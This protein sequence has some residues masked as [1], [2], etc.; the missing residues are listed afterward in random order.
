MFRP[1][2]VAA[3]AF[4]LSTGC[5]PRLVIS[6]MQPGNIN[7]GS[8]ERVKIIDGQGRRSA[9]EFLNH[10]A[11]SQLRSGG[12]FSVL[13]I[14][15][16][17]AHLQISGRTASLEGHELSSGE[18]VIRFDV[19]EWT[20]DTE[21]RKEVEED[22]EGNEQVKEVR[23]GIGTVVM[24]VTL[25]DAYGRAIVSE[26]EY[27]KTLEIEADNRDAAI[28]AAARA[29]V[30]EF[31]RDITPS[32]VERRVRLDNSD[33]A[34]KPIIETARRG[35][36]IQAV[37]DMQRYVDA[38]PS[39]PSAHYNLAVFLDALGHYRQALSLYDEAIR[40]AGAPP[41]YYTDARAQ[42]AMRLSEAEALA[43]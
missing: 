27:E 10:E 2:V 18:A 33:D 39:S 42:C 16:S 1:I 7:V 38:N 5:A 43:R 30:A 32:R 6:S 41:R 9:R 15:E 29:A 34:Q 19:Y 35:S 26:R 17:G 11:A 20:G 25:V 8:V 3:V 12:Y 28:E 4:L 23:Y 13:D 24:G 22:R 31:V 14:S 40:I 37:D 36:L 21:T